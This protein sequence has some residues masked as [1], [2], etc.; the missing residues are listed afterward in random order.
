MICNICGK[1]NSNNAVFCKGCGHRL[2]PE[3]KPPETETIRVEEIANESNAY[4]VSPKVDN[5]ESGIIMCANAGNRLSAFAL[6]AAQSLQ[7]DSVSAAP[8]V[9]RQVNQTALRSAMLR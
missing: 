4:T 2:V 6:S 3:Q 1:E 9:R 5:N 8:A 7:K